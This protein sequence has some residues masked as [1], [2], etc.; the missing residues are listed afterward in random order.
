[1][2]RVSLGLVGSVF[3]NFSYTRKHAHCS[4]DRAAFGDD[5]ESRLTHCLG[6][7]SVHLSFLLEKPY[8][9]LSYKMEGGIRG[10]PT[11]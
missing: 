4:R 7:T 9:F 10:V 11:S 5:S 3:N 6:A 8:T 1:M 2:A